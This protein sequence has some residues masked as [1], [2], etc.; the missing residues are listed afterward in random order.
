MKKILLFFLFI[1]GIVSSV[2]AQ[3]IISDTL[4]GSN[5]VIHKDERIDLLSNKMI[6]YN[7][8]LSA[9]TKMVNGWRLMVLNTTDRTLAM[10]IRTSLLQKFPDQKVYLVFLSPYIKLKFGNFIDKAE[11]E[12]L[13]KQL[14]DMKLVDGNIYIVTESVEQKP[15]AK[16]TINAED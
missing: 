1:K 13:R 11:A 5:S 2:E 6:E 12:K 15:S 16:T 3:E 4:T 9:K 8:Y 7:Q 10:K 14:V